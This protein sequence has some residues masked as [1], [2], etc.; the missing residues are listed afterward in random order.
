MTTH[1]LLHFIVRLGGRFRLLVVFCAM[2]LLS[3]C[4]A[5]SA[6][7][8]TPERGRGDGPVTSLPDRL[9][10]RAASARD[11]SEHQSQ[12]PLSNF[13]A[14]LSRLEADDASDVH[15][16][17]TQIGDSHTASDTFTG[18]VRTALQDRFGD[19]GRGYLAAGKPWKSYRQRDASYDMSSGWTTRN[20]L[21][22]TPSS[23]S[24]SGM[25]IETDRQGEWISRGPCRRCDAGK[26][27]EKGQIYYLA[28]PDG[29]HFEVQF[30]AD[31]PTQVSTQADTAELR[32]VEF[33]VSDE[34]A[35][36]RIETQ[37]DGLVTL[38]GTSFIDAHGVTFD[39]IGINGAQLRH[40]LQFDD[41]WTQV[42]L[43]AMAPDVVVIAFGAN[44][45]MARRYRVPDP[46]TQALELLEKLQVYHEE[47]LSLLGRYHAA[48]D[49]VE[50]IVLLPP[51]MLAG[52]DGSC[53]SY[54]F[55][56]ER[57]SGE[58]CIQRPAANFA[59]I[60]NAQR[61]AAHSA[62]CAVWDQQHAMG[63]EG[64][65]D[66]WR[67][68]GFARKDGVHLRSSGY[69]LLAEAF[70]NDLMQNYELWRGNEVVDLVT[71]VIFPELATTA[72]EGL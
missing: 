14:K 69:D 34:E 15:V 63:G 46:A 72:R 24:L 30:D 39:S 20:G 50:C 6:A 13:Y 9:G 53:I 57:L 42:E 37:G 7:S 58:R 68:L 65:M 33:A 35:A 45:T 43:A 4:A 66:V 29:G 67:E 44:E 21:H 17:I 23:F 38:F 28:Q 32:V 11:V 22:A 41:V 3:A 52:S 8:S 2:L 62:G 60:L 61:F 71:H 40:Y 27:A 16:R 51:D 59:G 54:A 1:S 12:H 31:P 25:R 10:Q 36:L 55:E 5:D 49:E 47:I 18:P 64:S 48:V 19:G 56:S 26:V 70:V